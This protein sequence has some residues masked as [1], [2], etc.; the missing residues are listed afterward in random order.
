MSAVRLT[1]AAQRAVISRVMHQLHSHHRLDLDQWELTAVKRM[2]WV[3]H[4][5]E[6]PLDASEGGS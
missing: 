5:D 1:Y 2:K 3:R 4:S 6:L